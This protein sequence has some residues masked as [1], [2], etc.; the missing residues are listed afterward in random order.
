MK[1]IPSRS[2]AGSSSSSASRT[3]HEYSLCS[4][5]KGVSSR[6]A[7]IACASSIIAAVKLDEPIARTLPSCTSSWS[8]PSV[9][10]T[11]VTPSGWWYW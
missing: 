10:S 9:S 8:A 1:P 4:E 11:G 7:A 2:H 3:S 5:T 6:S